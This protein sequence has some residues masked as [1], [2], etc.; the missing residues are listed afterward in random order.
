[1]NLTLIQ[2]FV[3]FYVDGSANNTEDMKEVGNTVGE[4]KL[5]EVEVGKTEWKD[6]TEIEFFCDLTKVNFLRIESFF[7]IFDFLVQ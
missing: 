1:M 4:D 3:F 2:G 5:F 7:F 6:D